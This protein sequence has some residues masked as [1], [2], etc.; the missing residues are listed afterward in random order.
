MSDLILKDEAYAIVGAAME[1]Y[2]KLGCG[3]L[4]QVYHEALAI[5]FGLRGIPYESQKSLR[6][7]YKEHLLSKEYY[8]DFL[9]FDQVIV[10]LKAVGQLSP[11]DCTQVLNYLKAGSMRVGLLFNF[12][13]VGQLEWKRLVI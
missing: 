7:S 6:I 11:I 12:G 8:V 3:F 2:Y 9:C 13:S 10:E 4:E 5:E 1:V